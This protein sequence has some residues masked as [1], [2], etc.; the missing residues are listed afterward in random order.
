MNSDQPDHAHSPAYLLLR[1]GDAARAVLDTE[2]A[3]WSLDTRQLRTLIAAREGNLSQQDLCAATA[4]DRTTMVGL[5]DRLA[6]QGLVMRTPHPHDRRKHVV[7]MTPAGHD[8]VNQVMMKL[9]DVEKE[10][11]STLDSAQVTHLTEALGQLYQAHDP[12]CQN[13]D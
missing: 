11:L 6:D 13:R 5:V 9:G 4:M 8:T 1:V 7:T 12:T 3:S 10:F 2:L